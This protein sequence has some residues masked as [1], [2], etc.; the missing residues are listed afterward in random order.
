M[1]DRRDIPRDK[2]IFG[3]SAAVNERGST[4]DC[5]ARNMSTSGASVE[6]GSTAGLPGEMELTVP[7]KGR[8]FTGRIIWMRDNMVGVAFRDNAA[9]ASDLG[10]RLRR[11]EKKKRELQRR[12]KMLLGES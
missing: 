6:F 1:I 11:S 7:R 12:I 4:R 9:D 2:V 10:E 8:S 3:G 5:V